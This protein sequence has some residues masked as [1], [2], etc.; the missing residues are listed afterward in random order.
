MVVAQP[1][2]ASTRRGL[3]RLAG[4]GLGGGAALTLVACGSS[5]S[6]THTTSTVAAPPGPDVPILNHCLDLEHMAITAYTAATPLLSSPSKEAAQR[7]LSQEIAHAGEL[8][9]LIGQAGGKPFKPR[10]HYD[11]GNPRTP[12]EVL[13]LLYRIEQAQI[14]SYLQSI[15]L[16]SNGSIRAAISA[17]LANDA[18]HQSVLA[19][20]LGR[21]P[22]PSAF[23]GT[24]E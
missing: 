21:N 19:L 1:A 24:G 14:A 8:A 15:Q 23:V 3:I 2:A 10:Q 11:L 18:Q 22:V 17:I 16:L 4:T 6:K 5:R 7:F 12:Y 9:G 20:A 13:G